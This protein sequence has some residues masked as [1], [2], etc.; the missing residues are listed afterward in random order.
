MSIHPSAIVS[1]AA[2]ISPHARVCAFAV[3]GKATIGDG[4]VIHPH[5][6][7]EDGVTLG[8][9]VEVF[10]SAYLGKE[11]KGAGALAR[12]P[13][14]ERTLSIGNHC[15]IGPSST[16]YYDVT[17]GNNTLIGDGASIREKCR[18]G[19]ECIISRCVTINYNTLIGDRCKVMDNSHITGNAVIGN[20]VFI[21]L[22]VGTTND[23]IVRGGYGSH[24]RGPTIEDGVV[25]GVGAT[26]LPAV[27]IGR[28]ATVAAGAVVTKD[29]EPGALVAGV[30]A[31]KIRSLGE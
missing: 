9:Y 12:Q 19:S 28:D 30:P 25:I 31:R 29:V 10:P 6:V 18:I 3:I 26:L 11:P 4:C 14:F 20:N 8:A 22:L 7:I 5:V 17:I 16:I 23:N 21:S 27:T 2:T 1:A 13:E 24:V 15:S